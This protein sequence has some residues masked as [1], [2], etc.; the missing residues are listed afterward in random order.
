[1]RGAP[2]DL[3]GAAAEDQT[4]GKTGSMPLVKDAER[5]EMVLEVTTSCVRVCCTG[6]ILESVATAVGSGKFFATMDVLHLT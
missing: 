2:T 6:G 1:M 3:T 4:V 5:V